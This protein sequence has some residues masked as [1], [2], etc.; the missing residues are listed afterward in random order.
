MEDQL[1]VLVYSVLVIFLLHFSD[2]LGSLNDTQRS[3]T[4]NTVSP[5]LP[6]QGASIIFSI[7]SLDN[8]KML[9]TICSRRKH[10]QSHLLFNKSQLQTPRTVFDL[11]KRKDWF[12]SAEPSSLQ[13]AWSYD[14]SMPTQQSLHVYHARGTQN[15]LHPCSKRRNRSLVPPG[16]YPRSR[17]HLSIGTQV[18]R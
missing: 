5:E 8:A 2:K 11:A 18:F 10:N 6:V 7:A 9:D 12:Y 16:G 15:A 13:P 4:W 14:P 17:P 3:S 1:L